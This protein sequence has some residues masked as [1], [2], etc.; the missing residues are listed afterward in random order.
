MNGIK[1]EDK[2]L[3]VLGSTGS[4]GTQSLD[5]AGELGICVRVLCGHTNAEILARQIAEFHPEIALCANESVADRIRSLTDLGETKLYYGENELLRV[6]AESPSDITLHAISGLA[7]IPSAIVASQSKT[8]LCMAN[9][10]ALI[11]AGELIFSNLGK[12]GGM[13][14]PV[15]S[16][17]SAIV[18]CLAENR[19]EPTN[20]AA[21][22]KNVKRIILTASG[23]PFY[24]WDRDRLRTVTAEMALAHPTWKMG[25]KITVDSATLM[26]KGFEIVEAIRLFGVGA[27]QVDVVIHRQSI[28]HSMVEYND[29]TVIA[30]LGTPD[31][32]N[33]VRYAIS[34]PER[35]YVSCAGL[36]FASMG[37]LTFDAPDSEAFPLLW[38]GKKA[39]GMGGS[40]LCSLI[41]ADEEAVA[42]FLGSELGFTQIAEAVEDVL[43]RCEILP[44]TTES[45]AEADR[46]AREIFRKR[47]SRF[48]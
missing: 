32:R 2:T 43:S 39:Y 44:V 46:A 9:K 25:K 8:R 31:M 47:V 35:S 26:N 22:S 21:S 36:D 45:L 34:Y 29:N 3:A 6:L 12:S 10:E 23:G 42:A 7:G 14:V 48:R 28:I 15:D 4:V 5:V 19:G 20:C 33:A 27:D 41:A 18:Q 30:Q 16:E 11:C 40:A 13:L 38:A 1:C 37:K 17:H 24:G